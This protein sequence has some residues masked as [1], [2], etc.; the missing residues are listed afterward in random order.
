MNSIPDLL[1]SAKTVH[2]RYKAGRME[3]ETVREWIGRLGTYDGLVGDRVRD[4][5]EW[6]RFNDKEPVS[7]EIMQAD[8]DRI[9]AIFGG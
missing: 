7:E 6:F 3:R 2:D 9:S 8:L 1:A 5:K 4:A